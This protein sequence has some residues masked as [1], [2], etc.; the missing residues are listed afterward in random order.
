[1]ISFSAEQRFIVTGASSGIGEG[2][3]LLLNELGATVIGIGR[4]QERLEKMKAKAK[5]HE[6]VF[7]EQKDLAEDISSLPVYVKGL[8]DKYGKFSGMAYCAG[9]SCVAPVRM[10]DYDLAKTVFDI[11]YYAPMFITKGIVDKR[12]NV[13]NGCSLVYVSSIDAVMCSKGQALY[14]GAKAALSASVKAIAKEVVNLGIRMNSLLLLCTFFLIAQNLLVG[15]GMSMIREKTIKDISIISRMETK[16]TGCG[17]C[18]NVCP[19]GAIRLAER[20]GYFLF[21]EIESAKCNHCGLCLKKCPSAGPRPAPSQVTIEVAYGCYVKVEAERARSSSGGFFQALAKY[22]LRHGGAVCGAA[23]TKDWHCEH[24]IITEEKDLYPL[25]RSKYVQSNP[26]MVYAQ[27]KELIKKG[28]K[29]LFV[30]TPC[31][32]AA[33]KAVVGVD[34]ENLLLVDF[35]CHGVPPERLFREYLNCITGGKLNSI[36]DVHFRD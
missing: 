32:V 27:T 36:R 13:G 6:N 34:C 20:N 2:V 18:V 7:L 12:N 22:I 8:K 30:G 17:A 10:F 15:N 33:C 25:Q 14:S 35:C 4:N 26:Q 11:N 9:V 29:V 23:F 21:P 3:A 19:Q 24:V 16:C 28:R 1:M 31:Q 5:H